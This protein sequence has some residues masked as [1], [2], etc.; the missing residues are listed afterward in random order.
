MLLPLF[1][2]G[3]SMGLA[4]AFFFRQLGIAPSLRTIVIVQIL[5]A[6]PFATLVMLTAMATLR[7]GPI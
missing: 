4:A 5:W 7:S 3:V 6:L 2:P 1:M